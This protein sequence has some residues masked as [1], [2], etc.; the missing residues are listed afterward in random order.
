MLQTRHSLQ[1]VIFC[2][3]ISK[4]NIIRIKIQFDICLTQIYPPQ[5]EDFKC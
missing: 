2:I 5:F 4:K 3:L 1:F